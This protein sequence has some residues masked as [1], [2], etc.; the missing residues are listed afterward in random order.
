MR[1]IVQLGAIFCLCGM[2]FAQIKPG[3]VAEEVGRGV[4]SGAMFTFTF[5]EQ[6]GFIT[7]NIVNPSMSANTFTPTIR[8]WQP[9]GLW[10][11]TTAGTNTLTDNFAAG[12]NNANLTAS[13]WQ[14]G[15]SAC[16]LKSP[17]AASGGTYNLPSGQT[18]ISAFMKLNAGASATITPQFLGSGATTSWSVTNAWQRFSFTNNNGVATTAI[19]IFLPANTDLLVY[20]VQVESAASASPYV[21]PTFNLFFGNG[22]GSTTDAP[23]WAG[24]STVTLN[25]AQRALGVNDTDTTLTTGTYYVAIKSS[26]TTPQQYGH[27]GVI[28]NANGTGVP[29]RFELQTSFYNAPASTPLPDGGS[30]ANDPFVGFGGLSKE[31]PAGNLYDQKWHVCAV[32]MDG[33]DVHLYIDGILEDSPV[34]SPVSGAPVSVPGNYFLLGNDAS[35]TIGFPGSYAYASFY[36]NSVHTYAQ[37]RQNTTAI[38]VSMRTNGLTVTGVQNGLLVFEG[39]SITDGIGSGNV[40][41]AALVGAHYGRTWVNYGHSGDQIAQLNA[42]AAQLDALIDKSKAFNILVVNIGRNDLDH[43]NVATYLSN[44]TTYWQAR[45]AAGW[46]VIATTLL[47]TTGA[48]AGPLIASANSGI[49]ANWAAAGVAALADWGSDA[50]ILANYTSTTYLYDGTHPTALTYSIM[51]PY[52]TAAID[53]L[54]LGV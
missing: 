11:S 9:L 10:W 20:G 51:A 33:T 38:A 8:A 42:R 44:L 19:Q 34:A 3:V 7:S 40:D 28:S 32:T 13:R 35:A 4:S 37:I 36:P 14:C 15:G 16:A 5:A 54:H 17:V 29:A 39:D 52:V 50:T 25:N 49:R 21:A 43:T 48:T 22:K 30:R 1:R 27:A 12:P 2:V 23:A 41:H 6:S 26:T 46:T 53:S 31:F 18:T 47:P 24:N 45:V